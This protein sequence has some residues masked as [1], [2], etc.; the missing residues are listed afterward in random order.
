MGIEI[1]QFIL[2]VGKG[3]FNKNVILPYGLKTEHIRYAM[4]DFCNFLSLVN[5]ELYKN[6][7][8]VLEKMLMQANFSSIVGEFMN[9]SIPKY[10]KSLTKNEYH[11][12]HPD[13]IEKGKY[14]NDSIQHSHEG[15]EIKAS[16]YGKG[17]QGHNPESVWLI[18]FVFQCNR[19]NDDLIIPFQFK[20]VYSAKLEESDWQFAGRNEG[21]R[22]TIT[23]SVKNTGFAKMSKNWIYKYD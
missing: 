6:K 12:G 16:R 19:P 21:S 13:L 8:A 22:R 17:W 4:D 2:P 5:T 1:P 9:T 11:N 7:I 20:A 15:I 3:K 23:A 14:D 10:C 18:V